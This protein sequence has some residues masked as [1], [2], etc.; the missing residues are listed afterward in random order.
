VPLGRLRVRGVNHHAAR[1]FQ[2]RTAAAAFGPTGFE[3][4]FP[5]AALAR[6][7]QP[8]K[9][10]RRPSPGTRAA[11]GAKAHLRQHRR[12]AIGDV[13]VEHRAISRSPPRRHWTRR[14][15]RRA[16]SA[17]GVGRK[18]NKEAAANS[19]KQPAPAIGVSGVF[20]TPARRRKRSQCCKRERTAARW[21]EKDSTRLRPALAAAF[22]SA[23][24]LMRQGFFW[25]SR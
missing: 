20:A 11:A 4:L 8:V 19:A 18:S 6:A 9:R 10:S 23:P 25:A 3:T 24:K 13:A 15:A 21:P 17:R 12:E 2:R 7:R 22:L 5:H 14:R 1:H 16:S